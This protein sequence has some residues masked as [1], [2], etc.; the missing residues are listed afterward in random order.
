MTICLSTR[1]DHNFKRSDSFDKIMT[2]LQATAD[3]QTCPIT[4]RYNVAHD[5]YE[6]FDEFLCLVKQ[7]M[8]Q[9]KYKIPRGL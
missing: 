8:P 3:M 2:N 7:E 6:K 4:I 1:E 9:I 5:N